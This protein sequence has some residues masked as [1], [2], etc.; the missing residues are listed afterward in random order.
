[1]DE[2]QNK[3]LEAFNTIGPYL[4]T[5]F[6]NQTC[7]ALT[8]GVKYLAVYG[9]VSEELKP[10][11][12]GDVLREDAANYKAFRSGEVI[13]ENVTKE[14]YGV[15]FT[16]HV[17]PIKDADGKVVCTM[18]L[19]ANL[20]RETEIAEVAETLA[21]SLVQ[22]ST[23][24]SQISDGEMNAVKANSEIINFVSTVNQENAKVDEILQ[25]VR[26]IAE[27]TN[28]LGLNAAIEAARAGDLGRGFKVVAEEIRKLSQSS[29]NSLKE[30]NQFLKRM[31][32]SISR[33]HERVENNNAVFQE[34]AAGIEEI[35]ASIQ[36]LN[37]TAEYLKR[38]SKM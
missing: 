19:V 18:A 34:Q 26:N 7:L 10:T 35:T 22:I 9:N 6:K 16:S 11:L 12:P 21:G 38:I 33:I 37:G 24:L 5:L 14:M 8:D 2:L 17:L 27:Q 15:P 32:N 20:Q 13:I 28:L 29:N 30:I 1:M 36:E 25:F 31:Q 3:F 4:A 23:T